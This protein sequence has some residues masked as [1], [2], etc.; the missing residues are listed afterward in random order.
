MF[1]LEI[2]FEVFKEI[3]ARRTSED[4]TENDVLRDLFGLELKTQKRTHPMFKEKSWVAKGIEF[5]SG[6]K[7][8]ANYKGM[9]Y[10]AIVENGN[11][12][13]NGK[14]YQSPSSAAVSITKNPVNGWTFWECQ[15]P[16]RNNWQL[17]KSLRNK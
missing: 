3:T 4:V 5:P 10:E 17:I 7:F 11:L 9:L 13:L 15:F 14:N 6:T 12:L 2:D 8:R 16:G 1:T